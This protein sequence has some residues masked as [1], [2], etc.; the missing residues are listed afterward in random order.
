[1]SGLCLLLTV[2][3]AATA[4]GVGPY[5]SNGTTVLDNGTGLEW[6]QADDGQTRSWSQ[7]LAYCEDLS[8]G[9]HDDWRLPN[10]RELD[11]I[12]DLTR[13]NPAI[14]TDYFSCQSTYYWSATTNAGHTHNAWNIHFFNGHNYAPPFIN[15][16]NF[17]HKGNSRYVRCVRAGLSTGPIQNVDLPA[18]ATAVLQPSSATELQSFGT[19][20]PLV[21]R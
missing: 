7:A 11:S 3:F 19:L 18:G 2:V 4:Y 1:M 14:N 15:H 13:Y 8:L 17:A 5:S 12:V 16:N 10:L 21:V 6:Q 9:G 20:E